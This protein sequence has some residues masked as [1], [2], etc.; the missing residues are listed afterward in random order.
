M[1]PKKIT[2]NSE[3]GITMRFPNDPL[4]YPCDICK[5]KHQR[6]DEQA[7]EVKAIQIG[8]VENYLQATTW[9]CTVCFETYHLR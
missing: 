7:R 1:F 4:P 3:G 5:G 6:S 2:E 8:A 9:A